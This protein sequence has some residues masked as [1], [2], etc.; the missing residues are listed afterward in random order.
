MKSAF[1]KLS[2]AGGALSFALFCIAFAFIALLFVRAS[3][4]PEKTAQSSGAPGDASSPGLRV[5]AATDCPAIGFS[6]STI[7]DFS[8]TSGEPFITSAPVNIPPNTP[9]GAPFISTPFGVSNTVSI[10]WKSIDGGRSFIPL[11]APIV[12]DAAQGP[13]GGDTH[14]DFDHVG[15][16]YYND[17]RSEEHTSELQ[18][19]QYLV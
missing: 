17:L 16:F 9:A 15:R 8:A 3:A 7:V 10:L 5:T 2:R 4:S 19:R 6:H 13:G 14:Q 11:G 12:R 18:S 1:S